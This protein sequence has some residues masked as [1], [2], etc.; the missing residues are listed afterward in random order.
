MHW[1]NE[2]INRRKKIQSVLNTTL[3]KYVLPNESYY[4]YKIDISSLI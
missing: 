4:F 2:N 3:N 1:V